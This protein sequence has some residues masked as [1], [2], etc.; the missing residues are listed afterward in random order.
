MNTKLIPSINTL[1]AKMPSGREIY[2]IPKYSPPGLDRGVLESMRAMPE[3]DDD[4]GND[5]SSD[6]EMKSPSVHIAGSFPSDD[7]G[8]S[9]T[10]ASSRTYF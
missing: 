2:T 5:M 9:S 6:D 1:V 7:L 4:F 3:G 8:R 10:A